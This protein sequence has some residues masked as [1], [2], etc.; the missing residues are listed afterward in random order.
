MGRSR[1]E[2]RRKERGVEVEVVRPIVYVR[3]D[4]GEDGTGGGVGGGAL[5]KGSGFAG[6]RRRGGMS[7]GMIVPV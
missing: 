2:W 5:V 3:D 4:R 6:G 7:V 1:D